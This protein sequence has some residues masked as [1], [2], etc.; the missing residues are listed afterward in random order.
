MKKSEIAKGLDVKAN[1]FFIAASVSLAV[2]SILSSLNRAF[3][4]GEAVETIL[5]FV[6][7]LFGIFSYFATIK[8]FVFVDKNCRISEKNEHFYMGRNLTVFSVLCILFTVVLSIVALV[9]SV[10]LAEYNK[11]DGL[12]ASDVQARNN[13]LIIIAIVNILM[14]LFAISSPFIFYLWKLF[15]F[16]QQ[17]KLVSNIA[18]FTMIVMLV[19]LVIGILNSVYSVRGSENSFLPDFSSI[20]N[21]VKYVMLLVFFFMRKNSLAAIEAE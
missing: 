9:F 8:G 19:H 5:A 15:K 2:N 18:L 6:V 7:V 1:S 21:S 14:Q 16:S 4:M 12:T 10:F 11:A 20:L 13:V 3:T 17:N